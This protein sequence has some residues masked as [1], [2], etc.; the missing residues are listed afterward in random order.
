L[1]IFRKQE[2]IQ[3]PQKES[4]QESSREV[5]RESSRENLNKTQIAILDLI[6]ENKAVTQQE[7]STRIGVS[8]GAIKKNVSFLKEKA[9]IVRIGSTKK[10]S[11]EIR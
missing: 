6:R 8:Y 2:N 11:W 5:S 7:M 9:I 1:N 10:G 4:S 3:P